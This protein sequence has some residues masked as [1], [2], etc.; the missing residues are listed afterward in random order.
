M[1]ANF[2]GSSESKATT[3][4]AATMTT[5]DAVAEDDKMP[6]VEHDPATS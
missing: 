3:A 5:I 2:I 4:T 1:D 6:L